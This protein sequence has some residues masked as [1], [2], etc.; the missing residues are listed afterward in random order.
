VDRCVECKGLWFD[1]LEADQLKEIRG[2]ESIDT[3]PPARLTEGESPDPILCPKCH[4]RMIRM[5]VHGQPHIQYES[6]KVCF[7]SFFD[8]GE[9][10][11]M[12]EITIVEWLKSLLPRG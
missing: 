12:K 7:G 4:T 2:S 3:V 9:F 5:V 8:A 10:A 1:A 11:D 6:C